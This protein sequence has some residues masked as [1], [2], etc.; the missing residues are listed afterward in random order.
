[1]TSI[2]VVGAGLAG[3][4]LAWR[5]HSAGAT[6]EILTGSAGAGWDATEASG[7]LVRGFEPDAVACREAAE[8]LAELRSSPTLRRWSA[9]REVGSLVLWGA[10]KYHHYGADGPLTTTTGAPA[11]PMR[12][13]AELLPG[14]ATVLTAAELSARY[15]LR[16]LPDGM[17]GVAERHAGYLSPARL[18]SA[19]LAEL[20]GAGVPL[21]PQ[22]VTAVPAPNKVRLADGST[23]RYDTVVL[24]TG[25]WTPRLLAGSGLADPD[26]R[27]KHVQYSLHAA[28]P[29]GLG[30]FLDCTTGL[31]GRPA[32][33]GG[34]LLGLPSDRWDVDPDAVGPDPRLAARAL[35]YARERLSNPMTPA[36]R[37]VA[38]FDCYHREPGLR[39]RRHGTALLSF[40]GGSGGAAKTVLAAS[41]TAATALLGA[42][43]GVPR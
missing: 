15:S 42:P 38:A 8:S 29:A 36:P 7:G 30:A 6:V 31:Y 16:G 34:F 2:A 20:A 10:S 35:E 5:L 9:Y 11:E 39:L 37:T 23:R 40:T 33:G 1:M 21:R 32:H 26:L 22:R 14:S 28:G 24:T 12:I 13:L 27:T 25:A 3:T 43:A 17:V 19:V 41:R 18:R 4:L